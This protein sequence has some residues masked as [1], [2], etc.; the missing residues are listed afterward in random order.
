MLS[1]LKQRNFA[2]LWWGGLISF[3]GDWVMFTALPLYVLALT[4]SVAAM[5]MYFVVASIPG[6]VL[7]SIGGVFVD[8]WDRKWVLVVTNVL[9]VPVYSLLFFVTSAE[10]VWLTYIVALLANIIRQLLNPAESSLL[11]KLVGE[12]DL[13]TA[14]SLN[15]LNN[16]LAR[17]IGPAVGGVV[18]AWFGFQISVL[19]D[20]LSFALA[21]ALI[22]LIAAPSSVTRATHHPEDGETAQAKNIFR[23]WIAG[24]N[25][26]RRNRIL[27]TIFCLAP[28]IW[29]ADGAITVLFP[30][31]VD[32]ALHGGSIELGWLMTA[33]AIGGL[34]GSVFIGRV[35]RKV[36]AWKLVAFGLLLFGVVDALIFGIPYLPSNI[37]LMILIGIPLVGLDVGVMTIIQ[38]AT[39]DRF[40]GR[41]FGT[42]ATSSA[43]LL[44]VGR[45]IAT[46]LGGT[47]PVV[48]LLVSMCVLVGLTGILS[49]PLLRDPS[50]VVLS[51]MREEKRTLEPVVET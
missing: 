28:T 43:L 11:P 3:M 2:L 25:V 21:A 34:V 13:V 5:G 22:A 50:Q 44:L 51:E 20:V 46:F 1:V 42:I 4:G 12:S 31:Y 7:G 10:T 29:L 23:E 38:I 16:N 48:I 36:Q 15:S 17:L 45:V 35:S 18:F 26:I 32:E 33:Q 41:V 47:V 8:R 6:I 30:V 27:F 40:R 37:A 39:P 19:L 9:L 49:F 24:L 14:N